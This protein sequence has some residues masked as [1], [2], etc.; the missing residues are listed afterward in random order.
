MVNA[1]DEAVL[2]MDALPCNNLL[3]INI[4]VPSAGW[5]V[6]TANVKFSITHTFEI[7]DRWA[8][9]V[10][11]APGACSF[12][13]GDWM[14]EIP[15]QNPSELIVQLSGHVVRVYAVGAGSHTYYLN[16]WMIQGLDVGDSVESSQA[17]AVFYPS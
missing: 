2:W 4:N 10:A 7:E 12:E 8:V 11:T 15:D 16:G 9:T 1:S 17:V 5:V 6:I 3:T 13:P 14:D